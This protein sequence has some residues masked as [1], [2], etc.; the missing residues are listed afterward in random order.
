MLAFWR[1]VNNGKKGTNQLRISSV[2]NEAAW[3]ARA[4]IGLQKKK[5]KER[6]NRFVI[7]AVSW[8]AKTCI[9]IPT[10]LQS[11]LRQVGDVSLAQLNQ[12][13]L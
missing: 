12:Q 7:K 3:F 11:Y 5:K 10:S 13:L 8:G 6:V 2:R 1:F 4:K 9:S